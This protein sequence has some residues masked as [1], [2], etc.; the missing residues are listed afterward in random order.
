MK[1]NWILWGFVVLEQKM[2]YR[3][4][5]SGSQNMACWKFYTSFVDDIPT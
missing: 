5:S 4:L 1:Y 3:D 2:I